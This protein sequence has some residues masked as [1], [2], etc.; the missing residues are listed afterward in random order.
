MSKRKRDKNVYIIITG[1]A[2]GF[3]EA[4]ALECC[5]K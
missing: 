1:G 3:G 2:S 4:I 5:K